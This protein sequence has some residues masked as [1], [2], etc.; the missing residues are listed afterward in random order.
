METNCPVAQF[1]SHRIQVIGKSQTEIA[2]EVGFDRP[3][4]I[5]MI[6]QGKTK[7]PMAK[8]G[9]MAIALEADPVALMKLCMS[10]YYPDTWK[11]LEEHFESALTQEELVMVKAWRSFV[12]TPYLAA[13][14]EEQKRHLNAFLNSLRTP[15]L[16]N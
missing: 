5:T 13:L 8:I 1:I 3:N 6:K 15:E 2:H 7:L 4:M 16:M 10:A 12:G 11:R 14:T 9:P